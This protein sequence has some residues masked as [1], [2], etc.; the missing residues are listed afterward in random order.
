MTIKQAC[1]ITGIRMYEIERINIEQLKNIIEYV[2]A[3]SESEYILH[4][5]N[6]R[7][8]VKAYKTILKHVEEDK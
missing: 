3:T 2:E 8:Y 6:K 7:E 5:H 1:E 4:R